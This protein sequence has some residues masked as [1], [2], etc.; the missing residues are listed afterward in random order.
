MVITIIAEPR[1]GSTNLGK[2][3]LAKKEF[4]VLFE[5]LIKP[6]QIIKK[7]NRLMNGSIILIIF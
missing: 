5:P 4:T 7:V 1:T 3:F 6:V 2:W